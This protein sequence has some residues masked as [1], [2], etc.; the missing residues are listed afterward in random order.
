M[1]CVLH[2]GGISITMHRAGMN[3][4]SFLVLPSRWS[5]FTSERRDRLRCRWVP[6]PPLKCPL[7]RWPKPSLSRP[8]SHNIVEENTPT[9]QFLSF[10]CFLHNLLFH[11]IYQLSIRPGH[12]W[13]H[14]LILLRLFSSLLCVPLIFHVSLGFPSQWKEKMSNGTGIHCDEHFHP[15]PF[16]KSSGT[17]TSHLTH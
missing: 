10:Y 17:Q 16:P 14:L 15:I 1:Y 6:K 13:P 11:F 12:K 4:Y 7:S 3:V 2:L 5:H 9:T 8:G